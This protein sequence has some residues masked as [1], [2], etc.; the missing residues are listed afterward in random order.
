MRRPVIVLFSLIVLL[1]LHDHSSAQ[2]TKKYSSFLFKNKEGVLVEDTIR[3]ELFDAPEDLASLQELPYPLD[4][5]SKFIV[6]PQKA[7]QKK[8]GGS[9]KLSVLIGKKG[10]V[11][12]VNIISTTDSIFSMSAVTGIKKVHFM[13]AKKNGNPVSAWLPIPIRFSVSRNGKTYYVSYTT[14][15]KK[16]KTPK[17]VV[18]TKFET[19]VD[20]FPSKDEFIDIQDEPRLLTNIQSLVV[21]PEQA[22]RS[23]LEGKVY[24]DVLIGKDGSV[25]KVEIAKTTDTIFNQPAKDALMKARFKP[26]LQNGSPV[27]VWWTVPIVFRSSKGG[28]PEVKID[29]NIVSEETSTIAI[30]VKNSPPSSQSTANYQPFRA[31]SCPGM[32]Y[33]LDRYLVYPDEAKKRGIGGMVI[34]SVLINTDGLVEDVKTEQATDPIFIKP[35]TDAMM[36]MMF[37]PPTENEKP[38]KKWWRMPVEFTLN[39]KK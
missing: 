31:D 3:Q 29:M 8:L 12:K 13:P 22:K 24:A 10:T 9:V 30:P 38:V 14:P 7:K 18:A 33:D 25:E 5:L 26:A 21:Y 20:L 35:A 28:D 34:L 1:T 15:A 2:H 32:R 6:Y 36:Q 27:K 17:Q 23:G 11:E 37:Y 4:T 16:K 19:M 39:E